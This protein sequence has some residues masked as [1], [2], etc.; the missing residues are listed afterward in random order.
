MQ[1]VPQNRKAPIRKDT[2]DHGVQELCWLLAD[3]NFPSLETGQEFVN[4]CLHRDIDVLVL[5]DRERIIELFREF[6]REILFRI[7]KRKKL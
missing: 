5:D 4:W 7:L 2:L 3:E 1:G 6:R